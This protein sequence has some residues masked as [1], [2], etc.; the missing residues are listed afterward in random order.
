MSCSAMGKLSFQLVLRKGEAALASTH[1]WEE[2]MDRAQGT[3]LKWVKIHG[4]WL[5]THIKDAAS[6]SCPEQPPSTDSPDGTAPDPTLNPVFGT[7]LIAVSEQLQLQSC[8][9]FTD[10]E[11]QQRPKH[12]ILTPNQRGM[13]AQTPFP[14]DSQ[15][16]R[17]RARNF[18]YI[19]SATR[20]ILMWG[21]LPT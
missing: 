10:R 4:Y 12:Q 21:L 14:K 17:G 16:I 7:L 20:P 18:S 6:I 11:L 3:S 13:A 5:S 1:C 9:P 8:H 19:C 15:T 2:A